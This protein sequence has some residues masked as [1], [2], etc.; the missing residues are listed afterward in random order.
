MAADARRIIFGTHVVP[1][2]GEPSEEGVPTKYILLQEDTGETSVGKTLGSKGQVTTSE[3]QADQ[4]YDGWTS[5]FHQNAFWE[6]QD[7]LWEGSMDYWDG[8]VGISTSTVQLSG[9]NAAATDKTMAF[10]YV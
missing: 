3:M 5:M 1:K 6:D 2:E 8:T 7:E 10:V 9:A 4:G